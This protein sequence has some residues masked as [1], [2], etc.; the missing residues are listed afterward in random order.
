MKNNQEI[1][2]QIKIH[3]SLILSQAEQIREELKQKIK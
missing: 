1:N 3:I 2:K